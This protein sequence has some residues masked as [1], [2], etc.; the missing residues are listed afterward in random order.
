MLA[1]VGS[2]AQLVTEKP[3][4]KRVAK[5]WTIWSLSSEPGEAKNGV[6]TKDYVGFEGAPK[7]GKVKTSPGLPDFA[8]FASYVPASH[9]ALDAK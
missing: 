7:S 9:A 6:K 4:R 3:G 5:S 8:R 1:P 2:E